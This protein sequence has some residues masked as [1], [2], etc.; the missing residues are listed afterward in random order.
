MTAL[1]FY[2]KATG[3]VMVFDISGNRIIR[4]GNVVN[5][6]PRWTAKLEGLKLNL[7]TTVKEFPDLAGKPIEE[8]RTIALKRFREK[9]KSI[10]TEKDMIEYMK[11]DLEKHGNVLISI[12]KKGHRPIKV[13]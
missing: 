9:L 3:N 6:I 11:E 12:H 8:I 2:N 7:S 1:T 5:G 10:P 13:K 4:M